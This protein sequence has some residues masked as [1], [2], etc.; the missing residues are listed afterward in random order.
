M[1]ADHKCRNDD[2]SYSLPKFNLNMIQFIFIQVG[3]S[4]GR[5]RARANR[6]RKRLIPPSSHFNLHVVPAPAFC[7]TL[8]YLL[9]ELPTSSGSC[10]NLPSK[11]ATIKPKITHN[12]KTTTNSG[13]PTSSIAY[14]L[15]NLSDGVSNLQL[16]PHSKQSSS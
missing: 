14:A 5:G 11:G 13:C 15:H 7:R 8:A 4:E 2:H 1:S 10:R 16:I 6:G 3:Y 12:H 9:R